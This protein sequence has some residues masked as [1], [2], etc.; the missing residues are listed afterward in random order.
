MNVITATQTGLSAVIARL[1][2]QKDDLTMLYNEAISNGE[3]LNEI[4]TIYI[5]LKDM[6]KKLSDLLRVSF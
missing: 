6:D 3:K 1:Q 2:K 5:T 4:K